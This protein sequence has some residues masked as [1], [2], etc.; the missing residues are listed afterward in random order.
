MVRFVFKPI[1]YFAS[2]NMSLVRRVDVVIIHC[3]TGFSKAGG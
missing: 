2:V 1:R 3:D